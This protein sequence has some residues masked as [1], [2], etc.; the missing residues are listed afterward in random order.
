MMFLYICYLDLYPYVRDI[1]RMTAWCL[2]LIMQ[3]NIMTATNMN[4]LRVRNDSTSNQI[5]TGNKYSE[6]A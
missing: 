2:Q 3:V 1:K 4:L 5:H 6:N